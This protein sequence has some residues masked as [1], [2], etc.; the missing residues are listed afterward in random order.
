MR[1]LLIGLILFVPT[2][3]MADCVSDV[4]DAQA[5]ISSL[6]G[7]EL[8]GVAATEMT[9]VL[10]DLCRQAERNPGSSAVK[11]GDGNA[12]TTHGLNERSD[13]VEAES[14]EEEGTRRIFGFKVEPKGS[15]VQFK[16]PG[17]Q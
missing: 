16:K 1:K 17:G 5:R 7:K 12:Y 14:E 10:L 11:T 15:A 4:T 13:R 3:V 8:S 2:S 9:M 6:Y